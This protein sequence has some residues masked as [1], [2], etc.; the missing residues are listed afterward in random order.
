MNYNLDNISFSELPKS[1]PLTVNIVASEFIERGK[2]V[3]LTT[4]QAG[5]AISELRE[6]PIMVVRPDDE[7]YHIY[8]PQTLKSG[9]MVTRISLVEEFQP[10]TDANG[11]LFRGVRVLKQW[12]SGRKA[13]G[14]H[15]FE[16]LSNKR[17]A[18]LDGAR[19]TNAITRWGNVFPLFVPK[20]FFMALFEEQLK[21]NFVVKDAGI[22][23]QSF[24][25]GIA[26]AWRYCNQNRGS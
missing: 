9:E 16:T 3:N 6:L 11:N 14:N 10:V 18:K 15:N 4:K 23:A 2:P 17:I 12:D 13:W 22:A 7:H 5:F 26:Q 8:R 1:G 24:G 25:S 19:R 20:H 21:I